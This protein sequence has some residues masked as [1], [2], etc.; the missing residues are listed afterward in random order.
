MAGLLD[1]SQHCENSQALDVLTKM[2]NWVKFRVD[3]LAHDQVQ[4]SLE[5]EQSGMTEVLA[6]LYAVTGNTNYLQ[7]ARN[8]NH[9]R[10]LGPLERGEDKLNGL[11]A[12]TQIP[13]IIGITRVYEFTGDPP[14]LTVANTF[15]NAVALNRSYII[16]GESDHEHFFAVTQFDRH[17]SQET[18]EFCNTYVYFVSHLR[19]S[20][21]S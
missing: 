20:V 17:L 16:G 15:W 1:A 8:F 2:A 3:G 14:F 11:H 12:N 13:K 19:W 10:V 21:V 18:C 4:R 7:L 6:N 9:E 5:T